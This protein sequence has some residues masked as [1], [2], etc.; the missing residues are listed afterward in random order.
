[1]GGRTGKRPSGG[2]GLVYRGLAA[3]AL[4]L[5]LILLGGTFYGLISR[6]QPREG[7]SRGPSAPPETGS[8]RNYTGLGQI[9]LNSPP[10]DTA[11]VIFS[12]TFPYD[13]GDSAFSEE[14]AARVGEFSRIAEE[15]IGAFPV[16][17][18]RS[19]DEG[20]IKAELLA[21]YN[22]VLRLGRIEALYFSDFI[23]IE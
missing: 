23:I 22:A 12:I 15:Y 1:M 18:L 16:K 21:R 20:A 10:P 14:L 17:Q 13:S 7:P 5:A 3:L 19:L 6:R 4:A 9:R 8:R 2:L 11:T